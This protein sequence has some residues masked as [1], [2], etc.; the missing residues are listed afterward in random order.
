MV[1]RFKPMFF[2]K[3]WGGSSL[4]DIYPGLTSNQCGECWGI[5]ALEKASNFID[6]PDFEGL[7]LR[8]LFKD[9]PDLFGHYPADE[10]PVLVKLINAEDALSVQVHPD[11]AYASMFNSLG[12]EECWTILSTQPNAE[13]IIGHQFK[14]AEDLKAAL[15]EKT[16][17]DQVQ[18]IKVKPGDFFYIPTGTLH[19]IGAGITLLEV[20]QSSDLTFRLYDYDR[21]E[22]GS[23]RPLHVED[24]I[25][26][27]RFPDGPIHT[28]PRDT[29]FHYQLEDNKRPRSKTADS[30]GD[31]IYIVEGEGIINER[32]VRRG[33]FLMIPA[34]TSYTVQ[35][36]LKIQTTQLIAK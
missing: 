4:Q 35:G 29:F 8:Q 13:L 36:P 2:D 34:K 31:Y 24:S 10:F 14:T 9:R 33:D 16:F 25:A 28:R 17:M 26:V 22:D 20:Q 21:L 15:T 27:M 3:I 1:I 18:R 30:Y 32:E 19:A 5:S 23:P 7:T 12:K 6:H 11:D